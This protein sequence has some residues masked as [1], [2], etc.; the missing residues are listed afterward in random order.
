MAIADDISVDINGNFRWTGAAA[1]TYTVLEFHRYIGA[2]MDDA[3]AS[4][5]DLL[6]IT[7]ETASDRS[8]DQIITLN[9]PYNIDDTL[10]EHL[11]DGSITQDGGKTVYSGLSVVGTVET[12]TEIMIVQDDKVL[13]AYWGTGIN[14]DA[15]N[16]IIMKIM[17]KSREGGADIDGKRITLMARELGDQYKEF[18]V[19][20][21]LANSVGAISNQSDLNNGTAEAT[22]EGWSSIANIEGL[23]LIDINN[24]G[25][26]EEYYSEWDKGTQ[27]INDTYERSK[28]ISQRA[29]VADSGTDT[30]SNFVVDNATI[31]GQGQEFTANGQNEKLVEMRF[32]LKVAAGT[33]LGVLQAELWLS[34]DV[35]AGLAEPT[36]AVLATSEE[37]LVSRL[38]STYQE[39]IFRFNDNVTMTAGEKYFAVIRNVAADAS[40]NVHVEGSTA[41]ADDGNRA[42]D[43]SGVWTATAAD[44]LWFQVKSCPIHHEIAG[45]KFR[46]ITHEIVYDTE[47]GGPFTEDEIVFWGT[48]ITY[49]TLA[50]GPFTVGEYVSIDNAGTIVNG[51][52]VLRDNGSTQ[53][54]VSLE[55][56]TGNLADGYTITGLDSGAT[57]DIN[58]TIVDQNRAGGEG[59]LLALDDNGANGDLYIQLISGSAPVDNL[60]LEGRTSGAT[61]AVNVTVNARPI[62]PE[63]IGQSTGSNIIGAYGIGFQTTD[64]GAQD[65]FRALDNVTRNPP[66]NVTM[67]VTGLV[68]GEDRILTGPRQAGVLDKD[69]MTLNTTLSAIAETAVVATA[70]IPSETPGSGAGTA[71]NT[72]IRVQLDSG[73]YKRQSYASFSSATFTLNLPDTG[74]GGIAIDVNAS[75]TFTRSSGSFLDDGFDVDCTFTGSGFTNAGNNAQ[76]TV[77]SLTATVITVKDNT[78]MVTETSAGAD[79]RLLADGWDYT[80]DNATNPRNMFLGYIDVLADA[81]SEAF[82]AVYTADRDLLLRVRDGGGTPIKTIENPIT[83]GSSSFSTAIVRQSDA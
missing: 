72:R 62:S 13:P 75:G 28:W 14:A 52:K 64:V 40:N 79:E 57:A 71:D 1:T 8:T 10:A 5:D 7:S 50:G 70:A 24:D 58:I 18:P 11:Y 21:G 27:T 41:G 59:I 73:V 16:L 4:G 31:T 66:N 36:G 23:R 81:T 9:S 67:T 38:S 61:A 83:F 80:G 68:A 82:T 49:D 29:H 53:M 26:D 32:R 22:I 43:A 45:E 74:A 34:D 54:M 69:Q 56:I 39:F 33:P 37:V 55:N 78:G 63:F 6:D 35:G 25:T 15:A 20:L 3:Q 47:V 60:P 17:V 30:G 48:D 77:A 76:F 19:T 2:L 51:G 42:E 65:L 44:D 12:G 46:G